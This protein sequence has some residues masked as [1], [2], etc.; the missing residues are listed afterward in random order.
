MSDPLYILFL[1]LALCV[2]ALSLKRSAMLTV[3]LPAAGGCVGP[4]KGL[5]WILEQHF[6][7]LEG[8]LVN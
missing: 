1:T 4:P 7:S 8:F 2:P 3:I 5:Q 6:F